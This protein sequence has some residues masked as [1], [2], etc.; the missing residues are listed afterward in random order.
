MH[1]CVSV[2]NLRIMVSFVSLTTFEAFLLWHQMCN[3]AGLA[4]TAAGCYVVCIVQHAVPMIFVVWECTITTCI[5]L[6]LLSLW[7]II[8]H[9]YLTLGTPE[10]KAWKP[11][12]YRPNFTSYRLWLVWRN[13][14]GL[15]DMWINLFTLKCVCELS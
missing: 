2:C 8:V 1:T 14:F 7:L 4:L 11:W 6:L 12:K 10:K 13:S 15:K 9:R 5:C 3:T